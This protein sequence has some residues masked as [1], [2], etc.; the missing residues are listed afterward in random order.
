MIGLVSASL[1]YLFA[2]P[3]V[4]GVLIHGLEALLP[5]TSDLAGAQAIVVLGGDEQHI[6][7]ADGPDAVGPLTLERLASAAAL[8]RQTELPILV[9]GGPLAGSKI[10]LAGLMQHELTKILWYL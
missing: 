9:S 1:L 10:P 7:G 8:Y 3:L 6:S 2:T 5:S 4:A